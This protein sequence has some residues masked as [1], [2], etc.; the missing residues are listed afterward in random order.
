VGAQS[1]RRNNQLI[2][3]CCTLTKEYAREL[4]RGRLAECGETAVR[5]GVVAMPKQD[6]IL[7]VQEV[8]KDDS[9]RGVEQ[10]SVGAYCR[11]VMT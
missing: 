6:G 8:Q 2:G 3:W 9:A 4:A 5:R 7:G 11:G 1:S 10:K